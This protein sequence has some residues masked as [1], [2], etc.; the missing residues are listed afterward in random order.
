MAM[1][2][3]DAMGF[4]LVFFKRRPRVEYDPSSSS[5]EI[6]KLFHSL[7]L[8]LHNGLPRSYSGNL[9]NNRVVFGFKDS[10]FLLIGSGLCGPD[11]VIGSVGLT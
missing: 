11:Y 10:T 6:M 9:V 3:L 1:A 2:C 4:T 8:L 5:D 7:V